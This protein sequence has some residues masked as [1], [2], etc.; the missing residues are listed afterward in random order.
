M[1]A[2]RGEIGNEAHVPEQ[3]R[4]GEVGADRGRVPGQRAAKLRPDAHRRRVGNEPV[5][6]PRPPEVQQREE[7]GLDDREER[8]RLGEA[9]DAG[10]PR[11]L[12][13]QQDGGDERPGVAD[14]DPPDEV[15]DPEG[16]ADRDV[17]AP[18]AD[19]GR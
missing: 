11:L 17:V 9:V 13:E 4:D 2:Q 3:Q 19:A 16:P 7:P 18:D 12:E 1:V 15:D 8:H 5:E 10:A 14:P 6:E